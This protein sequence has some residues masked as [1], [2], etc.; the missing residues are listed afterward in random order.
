MP[1]SALHVARTGLEAQDTRMRVIANNLAN[2]GTTGF[3]RDRANFATLAYQDARVA[4]QQSSNETAYATGLNLGTGVAVQATT[5]IDS[6][7]TLQSTSNALDLALDGDG[8]FQV[9]MP[10]G[11][12]AYTRAGNFSRSAEGVL[13]TAQGYPLNPAITIPEGASAITIANDGTVSATIAGQNEPAQLGQITVASF[14]NPGG[15]RSMGDNFLQETAASG[16]AQ[17]GVPGELG[18]GNIRQGYLEGSNVNVVEELVD[19]IECQ[20]AYEI[21]SK[22]ISAVDDMLQNANQTL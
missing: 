8:Y 14:A 4:G 15:L 16:A 19:M 11:Q 13:V 21:N 22:M 10:G 12:L 3:K 6:Q 20:R 7:G 18:R 17:V 2:V 5:R 1:S 9:T